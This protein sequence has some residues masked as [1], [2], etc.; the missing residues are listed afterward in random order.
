[1][2]T[3][4]Y[5]PVERS[6]ESHHSERREER[7][8]ER[9]RSRHESSDSGLHLRLQAFGHM[10]FTALHPT[11][12]QMRPDEIA[13][14]Y[15]FGI[16]TTVYGSFTRNWYAEGGVGVSYDWPDFDPFATRARIWYHAGLSAV[17]TRVL[18]VG[19]GYLGSDRLR[20]SLQSAYSFQGA[21]LDFS[22]H[23]RPSFVI[24]LRGG[25]GAAIRP[26][27]TTATDGLVQIMTGFEF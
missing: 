26:A 7:R 10:G 16:D 15:G 19:F 11:L 2:V 22:A 18:R 12:A 8:E 25:I 27:V 1:M 17:L 13:V 6:A 3:H 23:F 5:Y 4:F 21:Y 20:P 24:T 14:P 9:V